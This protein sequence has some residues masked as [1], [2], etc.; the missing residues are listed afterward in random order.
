MCSAPSQPAMPPA[1]LTSQEYPFHMLVADYFNIKGK[2][3]LVTADRFSGWVSVQYF[4]KEASSEELKKVFRYVF[5]TFGVPNEV[6]T[7]SGPQFISHE[8]VLFLEKWDV[9]HRKSAPY[10]PQANLKQQ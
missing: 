5:T 3:W 1:P 6:I 10:N 2:M 7:D 8:L 9:K 4:P